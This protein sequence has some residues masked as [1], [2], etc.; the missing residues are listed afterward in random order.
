MA[1]KLDC[2]NFC[3]IFDVYGE[4]A[5]HDA[6]Y[7]VLDGSLDES[8][9]ENSIYVDESKE[10]YRNRIRSEYQRYEEGLR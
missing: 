6:Y 5:A 4:Q 2:I 1:K 10:H 8:E 3:K 9:L 7:G